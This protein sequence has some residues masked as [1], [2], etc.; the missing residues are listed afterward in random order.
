MSEVAAPEW[1]RL[2]ERDLGSAGPPSRGVRKTEKRKILFPRRLEKG[3]AVRRRTFRKPAHG[4]CA[5]SCQIERT[6]SIGSSRHDP[7]LALAFFRRPRFGNADPE[8]RPARAGVVKH[9]P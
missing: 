1:A 4:F 9:L 2:T 5:M 7:R 3:F 6:R 8:R